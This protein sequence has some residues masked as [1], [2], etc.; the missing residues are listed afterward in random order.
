MILDTYLNIIESIY[1]QKKNQLISCKTDMNFMVFVFDTCIIRICNK[2]LYDTKYRY[3]Y[4]TI[5]ELN[6]IYLEKIYQIDE[7]NDYICILSKKIIPIIDYIN[8][9]SFLKKKFINSKNKII[10]DIHHA[11][12]ILLDNDIMHCDVRLDNIGYD[13]NHKVFVLFDFDSINTCI[14]N[15]E[16][17]DKNILDD[18]I[19]L[20]F[21]N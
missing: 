9:N 20:Y 10:N 18:S 14:N 12:N 3:Y 5:K 1:C 7:I 16:Y 6:C 15:K 2:K 13:E 19:K 11:I 4:K 17:D 8:N 21:K